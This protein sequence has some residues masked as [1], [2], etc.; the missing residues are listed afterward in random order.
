M[1]SFA[2]H[3]RQDTI[4]D[5]ELVIKVS[6]HAQESQSPRKR[7]RLDGEAVLQDGAAAIEDLLQLAVLPAHKII[8]FSSEYFEAQ[9]R[10]PQGLPLAGQAMHESFKGGASDCIAA[11]LTSATHASHAVPRR[12]CIKRDSQMIHATLGSNGKCSTTNEKICSQ[13]TSSSTCH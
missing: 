4:A 6:D 12:V 9:V 10:T 8:L 7:A 5:V 11:E 2:R 1:E 13:C 3:F